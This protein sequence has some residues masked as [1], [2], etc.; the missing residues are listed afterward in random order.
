MTKVTMALGSV[1]GRF[2]LGAVLMST[3]VV[4]SPGNSATAQQGQG[5]YVTQAAARLGKLI[6]RANQDGYVLQDNNFSIGGGWLKQSKTDWIPLYTLTLQAG[7]NYRFIAA[8]DADAK[9]VDLDIQDLNGRTLKADGA[10]PQ[11]VVNFS[12]D[13]TGKYLVRVRLYDS[14]QNLPCVCLAIVLSAK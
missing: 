14:N 2:V 1:R 7:R 11:A 8:G 9:D 3:L 12:P 10:E 5:Q 6:V 4:L 13:V